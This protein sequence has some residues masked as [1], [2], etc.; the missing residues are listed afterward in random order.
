MSK[1]HTT[2]RTSWV[3]H[4]PSIIG[5]QIDEAVVTTVEFTSCTSGENMHTTPNTVTTDC[6]TPIVRACQQ[7]GVS[8]R[9]LVATV[10]K[11]TELHRVNRVILFTRLTVSIL[12]CFKWV[13][14]PE[15]DTVTL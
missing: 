13:S 15:A 14:L 10:G 2:I 4:S 3:N 11:L 6:D 12:G 5:L 1:P 7:Q 8:T 9:C